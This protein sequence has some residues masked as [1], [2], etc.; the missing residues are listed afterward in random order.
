MSL[1]VIYS[2]RFGYIARLYSSGEGAVLL[3]V[4]IVPTY[5]RG[6]NTGGEGGDGT[7]FCWS[8]FESDILFFFIL[9][10]ND[11]SA[12]KCR[13]PPHFTYL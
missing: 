11:E 2:I 4:Q 10:F 1:A 5:L 8:E 12:L 9:F 7:L 13:G 3:L 6:S